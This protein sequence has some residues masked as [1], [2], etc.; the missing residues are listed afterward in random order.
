LFA[1]PAWDMLLDLFVARVE[2]RLISTS[3]AC[4]GASV[5]STTGLRWLRTLETQG[6][7][8]RAPDQLDRR[9]RFISLTSSAMAAVRAWTIEAMTAL[10]D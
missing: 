6:L 1:D 3:S 10:R 5:A 4:I 9:Q 8:Q 2:G 7:V